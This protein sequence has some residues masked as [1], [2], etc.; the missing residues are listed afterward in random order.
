MRRERGV[1]LITSLLVVALATT[2]AVGM[3]V[4]D[5]LQI[6]RTDW[7]FTQDRMRGVLLGGEVMARRLLERVAP[8]DLPWEQCLSPP[9]PLLVDGIEITAR[10]ENLHCR[11]NLNALQR[12]DDAILR[13]FIDLVQR[14]GIAEERVIPPHVATQLAAAARD[15]MNGAT[16]DPVYRLRA[17]P[18]RSANRP[19]LM[20]AE[21]NRVH[22]MNREIWDAVAPYVTALPVTDMLIDREHAPDVVNLAT[23]EVSD[24]GSLRFMRLQLAAS[25]RGRTFFHC[26]I[27]DAPNGRTV[28]RE[29]RPCDGG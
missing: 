21:L 3:A 4:R 12:D 7:L 11:F 28:V 25:W 26:A 15:W 2:V 17:V 10:L 6:Q 8:G 18:E 22:T 19:F 1:A 20:A 29:F 13:A 16:D 14:A 24:E 23:A 9:V 27:L 5:N